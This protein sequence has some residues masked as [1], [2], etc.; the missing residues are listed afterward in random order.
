MCLGVGGREGG[1]DTE[2][3][4]EKKKTK[5]NRT[6]QLVQ[7]QLSEAERVA[8]TAAHVESTAH[9]SLIKNRKYFE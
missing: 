4:E 3:G 6:T 8:N 7:V 9:T 1:R 5:Q 2:E